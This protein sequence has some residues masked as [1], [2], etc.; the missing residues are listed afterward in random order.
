MN[1]TI[2][3]KFKIFGETCKVK[4]VIKVDKFNSWGENNPNNNTIKIKRDLN[5][6]QKQQ[7]FLHEI[8]HCILT[9]LQYNK[10][11]EDEKFVD[12]FSKALHQILTTSE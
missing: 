11:N 3:K 10:L 8:T 2:P 6:E 5:E 7:V 1:F 4:Q 9:H 12:T